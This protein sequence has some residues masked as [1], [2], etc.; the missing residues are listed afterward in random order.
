MKSVEID[1]TKRLRE[2][3]DKGHNRWHPNIPPILHVDRGDEVTLE[4][5]D[6]ADGQIQPG[7]TVDDFPGMDTKVGHPLT[8]PVDVNGAEPGDLLEIENLD[9]LP[10][11]RGW[12]RIRPGAGFL[13]DIFTEPYLVHWD[14]RD[15]WA[16]SEQIPGVRLPNGSF[17]G[18]AGLAPSHA[19]MEAWRRR[20]ADLAERGERPCLRTARTPCPPAN[21]SPAKGSE[22]RRLVRTAG[23]PT[24]SS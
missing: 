22:P 19:Q 15:G 4:T 8:G 16:T 17:M 18:T 5:R 9:I 20:E 12:T 23:T 14:I 6:A 2:E 1:R 21:P 3:P 7:T 24:R 10:Q 11:P 13:R